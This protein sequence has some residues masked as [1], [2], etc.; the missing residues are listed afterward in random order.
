MSLSTY[1]KNK[2]MSQIFGGTIFVSLHSKPPGEKGEG[3]IKGG[4]YSRQEITGQFKSPTPGQGKNVTKISFEELP[5][6]EIT[7]IAVW[8]AKVGGNLLWAADLASKRSVQEGDSLSFKEG[9]IILE[10]A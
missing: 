1:S 6:T 2:V 10:I 5:E 3:E 4:S 9:K 7:H 8:D